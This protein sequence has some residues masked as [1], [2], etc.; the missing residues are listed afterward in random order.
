MS[1]AHS[2]TT[3]AADGADFHRLAVEVE[4]ETNL[5]LR[6]LEPFVIHDVLPSRVAC[7]ATSDGLAVEIV[8]A[9]SADLAQRLHGRLSVMVGARDAVLSPAGRAGGA[10][11]SEHRAASHRAA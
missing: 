11:A 9:A 10:V 7:A 1:H 4:P 6:L 3:V 8:F 5:L 2:L